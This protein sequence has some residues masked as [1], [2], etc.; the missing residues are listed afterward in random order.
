MSTRATIILKKGRDRQNVLVRCDGYPDAPAGVEP[1]LAAILDDDYCI[2]EATRILT[3]HDTYHAVDYVEKWS[4]YVYIV[5]L[6]QR[7]AWAFDTLTLQDEFDIDS[8]EWYEFDFY[9]KP[10][11]ERAI[12]T[13]NPS[14][15]PLYRHYRADIK[16]KGNDT[17]LHPEHLGYKTRK[18]LEEFWGVH[19]DD[20]EWFKIYE[21]D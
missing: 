19:N 7:K 4:D 14:V 13:Y 8:K 15:R 20:V 2:T 16:E 1:K 9:T 3:E 18:E 17:I 12:A 10:P 6:D 5:D 21:V 11:Y